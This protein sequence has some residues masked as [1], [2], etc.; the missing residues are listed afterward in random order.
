MTVPYVLEVVVSGIK[1]E[2]GSEVALCAEVYL[3]RELLSE[4]GDGDP[5]ETLRSD[6]KN[7]LS[8]LPSYKRIAKIILRDTEFEKTT[9]KKIK[10]NYAKN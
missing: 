3:D 7:A 1:D 8:P 9:S 5:I 4:S 6:I 2:S 10:R